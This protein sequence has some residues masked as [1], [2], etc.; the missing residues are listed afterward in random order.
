M[1]NGLEQLTHNK[2]PLS[3]TFPAIMI[4][5]KLI[6]HIAFQKT[7]IERES[8]MATNSPT[9]HTSPTIEMKGQH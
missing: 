8:A 4:I 3:L 9:S 6:F 2:C 1:S 5:L 7:N